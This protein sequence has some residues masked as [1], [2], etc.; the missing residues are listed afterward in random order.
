MVIGWLG[1]LTFLA[2]APGNYWL[3]QGYSFSIL[4]TFASVLVALLTAPLFGLAFG[5]LAI[6]SL[7][8]DWRSRARQGAKNLLV[9][10]LI[11]AMTM[12]ALLPSG[13]LLGYVEDQLAIAPW[14]AVYRAIYVAPFDDNYGDLML[15]KCRWMGFCR[16]VYRGYTNSI[17]AE[18]AYLD[19]NSQTEQ[20][21]LYLEGRWVYVR[22]PGLPVCK[23]VLR[24]SDP[25]GKCSF[26]PS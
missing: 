9:M 5:I 25:Y 24:S 11:G 14:Q 20:V 18:E 23:E 2:G 10:L 19:F 7:N 15:V 6:A 21:A 8:P 22:S 26:T 16:Q 3:V 13:I 12:V 1:Y 17:S 4:G